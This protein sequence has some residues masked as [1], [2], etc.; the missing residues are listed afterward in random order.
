[1]YSLSEFRLFGEVIIL[2]SFKLSVFGSGEPSTAIG[3]SLRSGSLLNT[4]ILEY[5]SNNL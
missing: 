3:A 5:F 1:M 2:T 4:V